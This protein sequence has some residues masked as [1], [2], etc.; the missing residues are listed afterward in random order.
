MQTIRKPIWHYHV[1][2][3]NRGDMGLN[4]SIHDLIHRFIDVPIANFSVQYQTLTAAKI[5][6]MNNEASMLLIGGSGLYSNYRNSPSEWYFPCETELFKKIKVPIVLYAVGSNKHLKYDTLGELS[7]KAI[8]SIKEINRLASLS[9]VR[10]MRTFKILQD[11]G[12]L[13]HHLIADPACFLEPCEHRPP[14]ILPKKFVAINFIDYSPMLKHY[15]NSLFYLACMLYYYLEERGYKTIFVAHDCL[16]HSFYAKIKEN[17]PELLYYNKDN[18]KEMVY[19]YSKAAFSVGVRCHSNI[20]SFAGNTPMISLMYDEKQVEFMRSIG[21]E[22]YTMR[23][24]DRGFAFANMFAKVDSIIQNN[25]KIR[26]DLKKTRNRF[27][28]TEFSFVK[29]VVDLIK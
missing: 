29:K 26:K 8:K 3:S 16:E 9:S 15:S 21:M 27:F 1:M 10:D 14:V 23:I 2:G 12:V 6:Q 7:L 19:V 11:A 17:F 25:R 22:D 18:P 4:Q 13:E 20:F 5:R 28:N 24:A